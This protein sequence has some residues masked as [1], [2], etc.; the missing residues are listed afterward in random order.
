MKKMNSEQ[1]MF[2][3]GT[4]GFSHAKKKPF[5]ST[6]GR[7]IKLISMTVSF[8]MVWQSLAFAG[9]FDLS[10]SAVNESRSHRRSRFL[11]LQM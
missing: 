6:Y 11:T 3:D 1:Q 7:F 2:A 10:F 9:A 5:K 8:T 4:S